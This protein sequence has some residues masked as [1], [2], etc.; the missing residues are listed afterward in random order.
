[1]KNNSFI[2]LLVILPLLLIGCQ[3]DVKQDQ[4]SLQPNENNYYKP[5]DA[6][7]RNLEAMAIPPTDISSRSSC[8]WTELAEGSNNAL[9][10]AINNAC[11]GGVIYLKKGVHTETNPITITKSII[12]IGEAGSV[13]KVKTQ[14]SHLNAQGNYR[15]NPFIHFLNAPR[16]AVLDL[17][18][19]PMDTNGST[20]LLFENSHESGVIRSK[21]TGFQSAVIL[22]NSDRVAIM[23]NTIVG[24]SAW[25]T[26]PNLQVQSVIIMNGL[27]AYVSDN[28]ISNSAIGI[29]PCSKW[30]TCERNYTHGNFI[31][32]IL[33]NAAR[34]MILPNGQIT[35]SLFPATSWKIRNNLS[36]DNLNIGYIVADGSNHNLLENNDAARNALYDMELMTDSY[37]FGFLTPFVYNNTVIAG[38]YPN[39]RIKDC[40][41]NSTI[42]GGIR[43]NTTT[44]PCN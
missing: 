21:F 30:G 29:W 41:R 26:D 43:V 17:N 42:I 3:K 18:I 39:I 35:G 19:Q 12:I 33:C 11:A 28:D 24:T 25:K 7:L 44:D 32:M 10:A 15:I 22:E 27:S 1:M 4:P 37:R 34:F 36:T 31:G 2:T 8:Y 40:G 5:S 23:R 6:Y 20:A 38:A 16:S 13:L 9:A 14:L